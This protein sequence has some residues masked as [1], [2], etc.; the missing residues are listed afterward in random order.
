MKKIITLRFEKEFLEAIDKMA[1]KE[2]YS[3]RT[4]YIR[5]IIRQDLEGRNLQNKILGEIK[6]LEKI[7]K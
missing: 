1:K 2:A 7:V 6:K 5:D 4:E 3:S